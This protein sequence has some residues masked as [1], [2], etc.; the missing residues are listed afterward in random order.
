MST[1]RHK[2]SRIAFRLRRRA[3]FVDLTVAY[4]T[5]W[6]RGLI[7][8]LL[9]LLPDRHM[10]CMIMELVGN[11]SFTPVP[12]PRGIFWGVIP[13]AKVQAPKLNYEA[14]QFGGVFIKFQNVKPP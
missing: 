3:V 7:C 6:H 4:D 13:Q 1:Y 12:S 10:V 5:V 9:R 14:L 8:K 2:T 11:R